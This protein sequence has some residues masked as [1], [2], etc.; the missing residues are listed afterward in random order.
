MVGVL[1]LQERQDML[2]NARQGFG[3]VKAV[4]K[5][6]AASAKRKTPT[7]YI[8]DDD[9]PVPVSFNGKADEEPLMI[10]THM[11]KY[12]DR[13]GR[14]RYETFFCSGEGCASCVRVSA[15]DKRVGPAKDEAAL[16]CVDLRLVGKTKGKEYNG[17]QQYYYDPLPVE[18]ADPF[19]PIP[20]RV[21]HNGKVYKEV[22]RQKFSKLLILS[23][24]RTEALGAEEKS[25][26]QRCKSCS[27]GKLTFE[28][29]KVPGKKV[30]REARPE[31]GDAT[32]VY[33]CTKCED[34]EPWTIFSTTPTVITRSGEGKSTTYSFRLDRDQEDMD[35]M[36]WLSEIKPLD[37]EEET[38]PSGKG[39]L[40]KILGPMHTGDDSEESET[41]DE[42]TEEEEDSLYNKKSK[43]KDSEEA[44]K[45]KK[46]FRFKTKLAAHPLR[47]RRR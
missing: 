5:E 27:K 6:V 33:T 12:K 20:S 9:G 11:I 26:S 18:V 25:V 42:E 10:K 28:G 3:A 34:P 47:Y 17:E 44:P 31:D 46:K 43:K 35:E 36:D 30:L 45:R 4:K 40:D 24:A 37:L 1:Q 7:L 23:L 39:R 14:D 32:A 21:S 15:G 16:S 2:A 8:R 41:S 13:T 38:A 19:S 22:E 29:W